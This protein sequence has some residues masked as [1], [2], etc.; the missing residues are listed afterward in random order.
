ML[1]LDINKI[2]KQKA[3]FDISLLLPTLFG[4]NAYQF[5]NKAGYQIEYSFPE[6]VEIKKEEEIQNIGEENL[7]GDNNIKMEIEELNL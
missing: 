3:M 5:S 6:V 4:P 1:D 7:E 2:F